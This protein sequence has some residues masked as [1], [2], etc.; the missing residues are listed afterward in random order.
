MSGYAKRNKGE[1]KTLKEDVGALS[2]GR[3][4]AGKNKSKN[5][6]LREAGNMKETG[7]RRDYGRQIKQTVCV[8]AR[9][10]MRKA[11]GNEMTCSKKKPT[12]FVNMK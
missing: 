9:C 5:V 6:C 10:S 3:S 4:R 1:R 12:G 8:H 2:V 11:A 7:E